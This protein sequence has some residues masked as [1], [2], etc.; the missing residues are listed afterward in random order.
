MFSSHINILVY[1]ILVACGIL[2]VLLMSEVL[3]ALQF[4]LQGNQMPAVVCYLAQQT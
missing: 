3:F 4:S 2:H 1:S